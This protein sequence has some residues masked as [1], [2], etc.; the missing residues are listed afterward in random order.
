VLF[1]ALK[2]TRHVDDAELF[3]VAADRTCEIVEKA[4]RAATIKTISTTDRRSLFIIPDL[5]FGT[6]VRVKRV[7]GQWREGYA[8]KVARLWE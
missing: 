1:V 5:L 2:L 3:Q 6:M 8:A 4:G 7:E